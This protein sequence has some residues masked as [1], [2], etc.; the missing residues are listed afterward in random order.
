MLTNPVAQFLAA[1]F[2]TLLV[3]VLVTQ[4]LS[5]SAADDQAIAEARSLTRV[6]ASSVAQPAVPPGLV[7]GDAAAIDRLDRQVLERLLVEDVLRIKIWAADGTILYSDRT[8]LIGDVYPLGEDELEI[9]EDGGT[10][11]E[12]SDLSGPENRF[13]RQLGGDLLEVYTRIV[14]PEG[15]EL[16]FEVY[17]SVDQ[18][19][20]EREQVLDRFLPISLGALLVLVAVTTPLILL[21]T[22]RVARAG[23]ERERLLRAAV[24]ASDAERVRIARDLHDGVV[25]DLAGTSYAIS[26]LSRSLAEG[27]QSE[28]QAAEDLEQ[29]SRSLRTSMRALRSL[30]VEIYPPDLHVEGLAA[31]LHDLVAPLAAAGVQTDVDVTGEAGS[32]E[33]SVALLWRVAQEAVRNVARHAGAKRT[34][35]TVRREDDHLV[36]EVVDDGHGFDPAAPQPETGFGLRGLRSLAADSGARLD[37]ESAP[38]R[39]TTVRLEVAV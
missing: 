33:E 18:I 16:L 32:R 13:E 7:R 5:R 1:G 17:Y 23:R 21:L 9:L 25:Q 20:A 31:A 26:T 3:V 37:V 8:E 24:R 36:L 10:D 15:Q 11:A 14:S 35:V 27:S 4:S 28:R 22:R 19:E 29:A 30:L 12:L 2:V 34:S 39:G 6:L 38:G